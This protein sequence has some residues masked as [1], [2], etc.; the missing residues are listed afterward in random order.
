VTEHAG[1]LT[2][3]VLAY[4][5]TMERLVPT[6]RAASDWTPLA[7]HVDT[8][9]FERVGV[10][11]EVQSWEQYVAM[12]TAWASSIARFESRVRRISEIAPLVYYETEE[13]HFRGEHERV[14]NSMTVF[15]LGADGRVRHLAVYLQQPR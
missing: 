14:V 7:A 12:L 8:E 6:V 15:E 9:H 3:H 2:R 10:F 5:E 1:P 4:V 13:H 11:T